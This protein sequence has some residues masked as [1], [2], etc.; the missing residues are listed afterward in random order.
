MGEAGFDE[1]LEEESCVP[2]PGE[3]GGEGQYAVILPQECISQ[4]KNHLCL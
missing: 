4:S 3:E 2:P 1:T